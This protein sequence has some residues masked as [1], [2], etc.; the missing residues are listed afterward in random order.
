MS[1]RGM[2]NASIDAFWGAAGLPRPP[3]P[4]DLRRTGRPP[5]RS[6]RPGGAGTAA[7]QGTTSRGPDPEVHSEFRH[8]SVEITG[9]EGYNALAVNGTWRFWR[10]RGGRLAFRRDAD[11]EASD[12]EGASGEEDDSEPEATSR[13]VREGCC[14][15]SGAHTTLQLFLHYAQQVDAWVITDAPDG[16]GNVVADCGPVVRG[17]DLAQHWRVWDGEAWREDRNVVAEV[18]QGDPPPA[19]LRGLLIVPGLPASAAPL[20]ARARAKSQDPRP[21][22]PDFR[23]SARAPDA[24][25]PLPTPRR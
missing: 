15:R 13:P 22:V 24:V 17:A 14:K 16:L 11:L 18:D 8:V 6:S 3:T 5:K 21:L 2:V 7:G 9:R 4:Q 1:T 12:A 23:L 20:S 25:K 19:N 10:V